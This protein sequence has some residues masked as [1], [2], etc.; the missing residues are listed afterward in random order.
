MKAY[1]VEIIVRSVVAAEDEIHA[2]GVARTNFREICGDSRPDIE[3][4]REVCEQR[5]LP[6]GWDMKC[7]PYGGDGK[8][9]LKDLVSDHPA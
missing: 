2:Y 4:E 3:V 1:V 8:T 9:E 7:L 5:D 6:S